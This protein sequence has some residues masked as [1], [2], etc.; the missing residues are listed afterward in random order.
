MFFLGRKTRLPERNPG[1]SEEVIP[2]RTSTKVF[3]FLKFLVGNESFPINDPG[4]CSG[5]RMRREHKVHLKPKL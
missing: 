3:I 4:R 1:L 5:H 2:P